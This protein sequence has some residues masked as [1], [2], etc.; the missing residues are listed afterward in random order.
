MNSVMQRKAKKMKAQKA[1]AIQHAR[2]VDAETKRQMYQL[3]VAGNVIGV[4]GMEQAARKF[5]NALTL[6]NMVPVNG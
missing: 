3:S 5:G 4:M 1:L 2:Y 6:I